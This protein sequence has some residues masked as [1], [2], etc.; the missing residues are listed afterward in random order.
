MPQVST[1]L[2][3]L[4]LDKGQVEAQ[5]AN[6]Q[7]LEIYATQ[8]ATSSPQQNRSPLHACHNVISSQQ[9]AHSTSGLLKLP[10]QPAQHQQQLAADAH[11][12]QSFEYDPPTQ[13]QSSQDKSSQQQHPSLLQQQPAKQASM[14]EATPVRG[15]VRL[16]DQHAHPRDERGLAHPSGGQT[17]LKGRTGTATA[18]KQ[19]TRHHHHIQQQQQLVSWGA[20]GPAVAAQACAGGAVGQTAGL[21]SEGIMQA[22][23]ELHQQ[24]PWA[25]LTVCWSWL[26]S[27]FITCDILA[28]PLLSRHC[29]SPVISC[30][31]SGQMYHY[32]AFQSSIHRQ[33]AMLSAHLSCATLLL[34]L[35]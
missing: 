10:S 34:C 23:Q 5:C 26:S 22:L 3:D 17:H 18:H 27:A 35:H 15:G 13:G 30:T 29:H 19:P 33:T 20:L 11:P 7:E 31:F 6:L 25:D 8:Q 9:P 21:G 12:S 28:L 32:A 24:P 4:Q 1:E 16:V 2:T 14:S